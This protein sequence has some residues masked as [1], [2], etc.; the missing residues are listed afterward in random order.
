MA[1]THHGSKKVSYFRNFIFGVEDGLVSTVA[2]LAGISVAS[3]SK[4]ILFLSG[5]VLIF[6]EA[7][8]MAA[9]AFLSEESTEE[10]E[11]KVQRT[12]PYFTAAIMF[13]SYFSAGLI[14]LLPYVFFTPMLAFGSSILL[15]LLALFVLGVISGELS[16]ISVTKSALRMV[17]VGGLAIGVG[18]IV[19]TLVQN[20]FLNELI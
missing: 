19:S 11:G 16:K 3:V 18:L 12:T 5:I 2:F 6:V 10:Y 9:G 15:S 14:P 17:F 20:N 13:V 7:F 8:S 1:L 4:E